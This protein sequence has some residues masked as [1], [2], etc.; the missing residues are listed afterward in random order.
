MENMA[1]DSPVFDPGLFGEHCHLPAI[2]DRV[3][4]LSLHSMQL[5]KSCGSDP[6]IQSAV[7]DIFESPEIQAN[8]P[9]TS[10][11]AAPLLEKIKYINKMHGKGKR[12]AP[13]FYKCLWGSCG[14]KMSRKLHA[15]E[16]IMNHVDNRSYVCDHW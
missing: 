6:I 14:E 16:H 5:F 10:E 4:R 11:M 15:L 1:L 7:L 9:I 3:Q 12:G 13:Q 8:A 2:A